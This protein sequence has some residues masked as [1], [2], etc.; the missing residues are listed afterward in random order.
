MKITGR[1]PSTTT[2]PTTYSRPASNT[3]VIGA[4]IGVLAVIA[5]IFFVWRGYDGTTTSD[6]SATTSRSTTD[7]TG[8]VPRPAAPAGSMSTPGDRRP[9]LPSSRHLQHPAEAPRRRR[10]SP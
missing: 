1:R 8:T 5:V 4:I 2:G 10:R 6:T 3:G 9:L 7:T